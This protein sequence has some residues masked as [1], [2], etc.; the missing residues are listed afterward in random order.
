MS[1]ETLLPLLTRSRGGFPFLHSIWM[2]GVKISRNSN[3]P[4][5]VDFLHVYREYNDNTDGLSK[6][7]LSLASSHLNLIEF[8]KGEF[9][10][11]GSM[12]LF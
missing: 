7:A 5:S 11:N 4:F 10:G 9:V 3:H 6:E 8:F 1:K 2:D 12:H